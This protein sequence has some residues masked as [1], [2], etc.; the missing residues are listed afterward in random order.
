MRRSLRF[1]KLPSTPKTPRFSFRKIADS[2]DRCRGGKRRGGNGRGGSGAAWAAAAAR[3]GLADG[4]CRYRDAVFPGGTDLPF[5]RRGGK[6]PR[7]NEKDPGAGET[8]AAGNGAE[9]N[10]R[11]GGGGRSAK[12]KS[13]RS[14]ENKAGRGNGKG[15]KKTEPR[16]GLRLLYGDT[17]L[18]NYIKILMML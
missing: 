18:K 3:G 2:L 5:P 17:E 10:S 14:S 11:G 1:N 6:R 13:R 9:E 12:E 15:K 4:E 8:A 16:G 7:Q